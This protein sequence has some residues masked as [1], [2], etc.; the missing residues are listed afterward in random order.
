[1]EPGVVQFFMIRESGSMKSAW[2][3]ALGLDRAWA[4]DFPRRQSVTALLVAVA[5]A[6]LAVAF[7]V[8]GL[9]ACSAGGL[10]LDLCAGGPRF[11]EAL[12]A[13]VEFGG[14][15]HVLAVEGECLVL[16]FSVAFASTSRGRAFSSNTAISASNCSSSLIRRP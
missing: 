2:D 9:P 3:W 12:F 7:L 1:M 8:L 11:G 6:V 13:V 4:A 15:I 10:G 14:Q 5:D 16:G